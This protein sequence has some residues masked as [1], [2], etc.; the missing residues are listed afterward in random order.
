MLKSVI[1][2]FGKKTHNVRIQLLCAT[3]YG[4][5]ELYGLG[6]TFAIIMKA[7]KLTTKK[8]CN[9]VTAKPAQRVQ[10]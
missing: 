7:R 8:P 5:L 6:G 10:P 4:L 3:L 1:R 2:Y 9:R